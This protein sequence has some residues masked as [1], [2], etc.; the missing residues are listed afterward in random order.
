M[1]R[2]R[3]RKLI[4]DEL[5]IGSDNSSQLYIDDSSFRILENAN[6]YGTVISVDSD[7]SNV[8]IGDTEQQTH[9]SHLFIDLSDDNWGIG[10]VGNINTGVQILHDSGSGSIWTIVGGF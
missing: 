9:G 1:R 2:A 4:L 7:F 3:L 10:D 8:K 5:S 6:G